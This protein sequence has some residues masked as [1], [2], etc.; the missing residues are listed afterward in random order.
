MWANLGTYPEFEIHP[1]WSKIGNPHH[2]YH[3]H[4]V[5]PLRW[6]T[7]PAGLYDAFNKHPEV[8]W[9][10]CLDSDAIIMNAT[11][12]LWDYLL[13]PTALLREV[14]PEA[15]VWFGGQKQLP[16]HE[17]VAKTP[18]TVDPNNI[19]LVISNDSNGL[20]CVPPSSVPHQK[21]RYWRPQ[22]RK[23]LRPS[24]RLH[25]SLRRP[26]ARPIPDQEQV[27]ASLP[28]SPSTPPSDSTARRFTFNE[29]DG[30]AHLILTH[31]HVRR[32]VAIVPQSKINIYPSNFRAG[33]F[34]V[35]FAGCRNSGRDCD[36]LAIDFWNS[37]TVV[38]PEIVPKR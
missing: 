4:R 16:Q 26:L 1:Q 20:K 22:H 18:K 13:S 38:T 27:A 10:W 30:L 35:H 3:H 15:K 17:L 31:P 28:P 19:Y 7:A 21:S 2:H 9:I 24:Q 6:P 11:V 8:E 33:D 34:L 5:E 29:Q 14:Q 23:L 12:D 25:V 36:K 37:R 32:H